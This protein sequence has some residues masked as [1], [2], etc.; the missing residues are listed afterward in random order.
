MAKHMRTTLFAAV[1][2]LG[3]TPANAAE[4][5]LLPMPASVTVDAGA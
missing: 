1:V 2:S 4:L 3:M 5:P